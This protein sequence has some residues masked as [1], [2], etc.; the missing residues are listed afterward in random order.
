MTTYVITVPGTFTTAVEAGTRAQLSRALRPADPHTTRLG[1]AEDLDALHI[2][3][4]N[5]FTLRLTVEADTGPHAEEAAR[6]L[7][8]SALRDAGLDERAAPLGSAVI[9]GIDAGSD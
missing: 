4:D 1:S 5:T 2:N 9:T 3:E 7:A 8:D 6:K